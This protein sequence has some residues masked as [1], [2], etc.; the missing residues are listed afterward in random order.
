MFHGLIDCLG[1]WN[2]PVVIDHYF[3]LVRLENV[4]WRMLVLLVLN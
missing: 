2:L 1:S 4:S 3:K